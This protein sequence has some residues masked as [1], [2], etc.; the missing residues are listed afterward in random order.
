VFVGAVTVTV[1]VGVD[2]DVVLATLGR[3]IS[4]TDVGVLFRSARMHF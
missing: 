3:W 1:E 2:V 4:A